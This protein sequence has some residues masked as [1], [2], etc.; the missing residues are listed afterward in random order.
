MRIRKI[1]SILPAFLAISIL[2]SNISLTHA[3]S[4]SA[5][6][7]YKGIDI[8]EWQ[9][10]I[11]FA[12]VKSAGI[13]IVYIK[14]S[15]GS[16]YKDTYLKRNYTHAKANGLKIGFYHYVTAKTVKQAEQQAKFF[17]SVVSGKKSD[18]KLVMDF[19]SFGSLNKTMINK[20]A[21]KFMQTIETVSGK[22]AMIYSDL[23]NAQSVFDSKF[24][25]YSLWVADYGVSK[26]GNTK[27]WRSWAGFQYSDTG[28][29]PGI[30]GYVDVDKYT[31]DIFLKDTSPLSKIVSPK[32]LTANENIKK[33]TVK[34]GDTLSHLSQKHHSTVKSIASMNKIKNPNLIYE[35]KKL[36]IYSIQKKDNNHDIYIVVKGDTLSKIA[37]TYHTTVSRLLRLNHINNSNLI[38]P[39]QRIQ[40]R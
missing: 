22:K 9:G 20:I 33:V 15:E 28:K 24:S 27:N 34:R 21:L 12:K 13:K 2:L 38:Y 32:P 29:V 11:N 23:Y 37:S 19:E 16:G 26:A 8:S 5:R 40:T 6:I 36:K 18:C 1:K 25:S 7:I 4:P 30:N 35:G 39:G 17:L 14:S 10:K 3:M 31:K